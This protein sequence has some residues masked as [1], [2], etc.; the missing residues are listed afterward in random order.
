MG[1]WYSL[2][3]LALVPEMNGVDLTTRMQKRMKMSLRF[4]VVWMCGSSVVG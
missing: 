1:Q 4:V 2:G 3:V